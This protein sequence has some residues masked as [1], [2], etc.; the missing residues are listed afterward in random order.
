MKSIVEHYTPTDQ[1]QVPDH[2]FEIEI[3]SW[4]VVLQPVLNQVAS[5]FKTAASE[6]L[7]LT[8]D[9]I[10]ALGINGV[11]TLQQFKQ[12]AKSYIEEEQVQMKF[13]H[14]LMP[15]L[16]AFHG[17]TA[18]VIINS[19]EETRYREEYLEQ[20]SAYAEEYDLSLEDYARQQLGISG[21]VD[22]ELAQRA[23]EDYIFKI[24]AHDRV[25]AKNIELDELTYERFIQQNVLQ[26]GAD[27]IDVREQFPYEVFKKI[28][29]EMSYSQSLF[30]HF[31]PKFH[32]KI[33][34]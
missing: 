8:D 28:M 9:M 24:I 32:F 10:R 11:E 30:E 20:V 34:G 23:K 22:E 3:P 19:E 16:L 4:E 14:D 13:Y 29:P 18:D 21:D 25:K 2:Y 31:K 6:T 33:R 1:I 26:N 27:E 12:Y 7:E 15:F 17:E 5:Q